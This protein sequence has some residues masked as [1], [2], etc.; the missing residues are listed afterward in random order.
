MVRLF[1]FSPKHCGSWGMFTMCQWEYGIFSD[2]LDKYLPYSKNLGGGGGERLSI[3]SDGGIRMLGFR[4]DSH[5]F[6][7]M[8][9]LS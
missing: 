9:C 4:E 2:K 1:Q 7:Q 6:L 8:K 5:P 3:K